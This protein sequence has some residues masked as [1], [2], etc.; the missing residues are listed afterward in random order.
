MPNLAIT[1]GTDELNPTPC[2]HC[3]GWAESPAE[4][5]KFLQGERQ[6]CAHCPLRE[7]I[8][9]A[10]R[11]YSARTLNWWVVKGVVAIPVWIK[12]QLRNRHLTSV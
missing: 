4:T 1:S 3:A 12:E 8:E 9:V 10:A 5:L 7:T 11:Q 6:V 2:N